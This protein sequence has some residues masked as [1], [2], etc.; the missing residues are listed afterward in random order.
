MQRVA[1]EA[2]VAMRSGRWRR[3]RMGAKH[4]RRANG[5]VARPCARSRDWHD[6]AP[7]RDI[8]YS[9]GAGIECDRGADQWG[10]LDA[11]RSDRDRHHHVGSCAGAVD[12]GDVFPRFL[13]AFSFLR[14]GIGLPSAP[15]NIILISL[16][17]FMTLFVMAPT[18]DK[19]WQ[20]G[21]KP[22]ADGTYHAGRCRPPNH[23]SI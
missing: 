11:D 17:L 3:R 23:R 1:G 2:S 5:N 8:A 14:T 7:D 9:F 4:E 22:L 13:I 6:C 20:D 18:F 16:A 12:D 21:V 15:S 10:D 19:A